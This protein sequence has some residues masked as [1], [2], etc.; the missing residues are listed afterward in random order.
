MFD[1]VW[2]QVNSFGRDRVEFLLIQINKQ[3][4]RENDVYMLASKDH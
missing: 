1:I 4:F 3:T 2:T